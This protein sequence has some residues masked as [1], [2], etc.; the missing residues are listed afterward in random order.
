MRATLD[1]RSLARWETLLVVL[2]ALTFLAFS[3]GASP[4][5]TPYFFDVNN[6]LGMSG[7][8]IAVGLMALPLTLI[9]IA[10]QIDLSVESGL[11]MGAIIFATVW[12]SGLKISLLFIH[13][14]IHLPLWWAAL[15]ALVAGG[16]A[17]L[18]NGLIITRIKLPALVVT[19]GTYALY[20]GLAFLIL[21]DRAVD[22][23]S[24]P[25]SFINIGQGNIVVSN[26]ILIFLALAALC[27]LIFTLVIRLE[28][29]ASYWYLVL[30]PVLAIVARLIGGTGTT[31]VP[32]YL[33]PF[34]LLVIVFGIVLHR[35]SF[36]RYVYAIGSNE[37]AC[38]YS[39]VRV[40]TIIT[41]LFIVSGIMA[42]FAGLVEASRLGSAR[43]DI[44]TGLLLDV[45]TAVVLGGVD[46][47]GGRGTIVGP[48]L[49]L[50]LIALLRGGLGLLQISDDVANLLVGCL[51]IFS[52][53]IPHVFQQARAYFERRTRYPRVSVVQ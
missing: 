46:I 15:F 4:W 41:I 31:A 14:V 49:A 10:G 45:V 28:G 7:R 21:G 5:Y 26:S 1:V 9:V 11:A 17:G 35:S 16:A 19:L 32:Q 51:L 12:S 22:L 52:I 50:I 2:I 38:R 40:A 44:G 29:V 6:L 30:I 34:A 33:L 23:T 42:A 47:F 37:E 39:G 25:S 27:L 3:L 48:V 24:A 20:R 18:F 53:L 36:G 43:A 8:V 13:I